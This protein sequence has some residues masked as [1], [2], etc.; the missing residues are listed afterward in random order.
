MRLLGAVGLHVREDQHLDRAGRRNTFCPVG[1][2]EGLC[3]QREQQV[4]R[5]SVKGPSVSGGGE[6]FRDVKA[7]ACLPVCACA[8][9]HVG[10]NKGVG[11]RMAAD[12]TQASISP[13]ISQEV[14]N[15]ISLSFLWPA[16]LR[17]VRPYFENSLPYNQR[18]C[19]LVLRRHEPISEGLHCSQVLNVPS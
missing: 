14:S 1:K 10:D 4:K 17:W 12:E 6:K 11:R 5:G 7:H 8:C 16:M 15:C 13:L 19:E 2:E 9:A 3:R 18:N